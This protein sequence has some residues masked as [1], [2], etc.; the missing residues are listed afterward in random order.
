MTNQTK[1][2]IDLK[3][4]AKLRADFGALLNRVEGLQKDNAALR[5]RLAHAVARI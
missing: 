4:I 5:H 2:T 1:K 3:R